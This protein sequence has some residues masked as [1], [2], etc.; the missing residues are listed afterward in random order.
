M[1]R[2]TWLLVVC[3]AF[4]F[5][6]VSIDLTLTAIV[7]LSL[8]PTPAL[9]TLPLAAI[10]VVGT[11]CSVA[12]GLLAARFGYIAVMVGGAVTAVAGAGLSVAAVSTHSFWLLCVGTGLVGAYRST[13]GYIRYMAAD[14]A[15]DGQRERALSFILYGGLVAAFAGPFVATL[16]SD[17]LGAR[18]AGAYLMVGV[19]AL[20][21]V[22]LLLALRAGKVRPDVEAEKPEPVPLARVRRSK[23]FVAALLALAGSGALMTMIMAVGPL[24]SQHAGHSESLGAAIIQWHLVGMFAPAVVSGAVLSRI[25][26]WWTSAIGTALF[27]VGSLVGLAGEAFVNFL[28]GLALN[29]VGWNFLYLAGTAFLVRCYPPGRGGRIQA[30]AEGLTSLSSVAASVSA[31]TVFLLLGWRGTNGPVLVVSALLLVVLAVMAASGRRAAPAAERP[32]EAVR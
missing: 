3:Q 18:Y 4:Y 1:G 32:A 13:G 16:S 8:A 22:P 27:L 5:M 21:N 28:V 19:Y 14:R 2:S 10:T 24:G 31:S 12:A 23:D 20:A 9:A 11:L 30:V 25:G 15:P 6:G 29:G 17:L 26:P 7:G